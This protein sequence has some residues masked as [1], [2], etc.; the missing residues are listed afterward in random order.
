MALLEDNPLL[1]E[2]SRTRGSVVV[3]V[4]G[5]L[6][7]STGHLLRKGL[8]DLIDGQGNLSLVLDVSRV[9]FIDSAGIGVL[10][11]AHRRLRDKGGSL[12]LRAPSRQMAGVL[13][14]TGL[15]A[16]LTVVTR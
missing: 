6:D 9:S 14:A 1:I 16:T 3:T 4:R 10:V 15:S 5:D 7:V 11:G 8:V 12:V 13:D 2:F